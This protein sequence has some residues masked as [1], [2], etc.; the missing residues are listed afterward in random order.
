M[1]EKMNTN[2]IDSLLANEEP[3]ETTEEIP[4]GFELIELTI[5]QFALDTSIIDW[6][7]MTMRDLIQSK[8]VFIRGRFNLIMTP[9]R[10][11]ELMDLTLKMNHHGDGMSD[12]Q[13]EELKKK[14]EELKTEVDE[15]A[16]L[17]ES[18]LKTGQQLLNA[19]GCDLDYQVREGITNREKALLIATDAITI[20]NWF[21]SKLDEQTINDMKVVNE[22][23][24][25]SDISVDD[26]TTSGLIEEN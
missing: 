2:L 20:Y 7:E 26:H 6:D 24:S 21:I 3:I 19:I 8:N 25:V 4:E 22:R 13:F 16:D 23:M 5:C 15:M 17:V 10:G 1:E 14:I 9:D 18:I 12:E 11:S